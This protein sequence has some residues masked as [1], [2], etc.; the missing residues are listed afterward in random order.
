MPSA[1]TTSAVASSTATESSLLL[2]ARPVSVALKNSSVMD[3]AR[4]VMRTLKSVPG[5]VPRIDAR[6]LGGGLE[7]TRCLGGAGAARSR[8]GRRVG[9]D[10]PGQR[11]QVVGEL[12]AIG[13]AQFDAFL[14]RQRDDIGERLGQLRAP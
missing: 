12:A 11:E 4:A 3:W 5:I 13:I 14:E 9:V 10:Q 2:R 1:R 6:K 7:S 8:H